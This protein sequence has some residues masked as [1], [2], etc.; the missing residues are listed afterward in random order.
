MKKASKIIITFKHLSL[1]LLLLA[2]LDI[3]VSNIFIIP[4]IT[5]GTIKE[6]CLN[7]FIYYYLKLPTSGDVVIPKTIKLHNN[8]YVIT[9]IGDELFEDNTNITS[10]DIPSTVQR[11]GAFAFNNCKGLK[12]VTLHEGLTEIGTAAFQNSGIENLQIPSSVQIIDDFAFNHCP[13]WNI[14]TLQLPHHLKQLGKNVL[15][16]THIF[17]DVGSDNEFTNFKINDENKFYT[18]DDGILYTKDKHT[19]ISIPRGKIFDDNTYIMPDSVTNLAEMAFSRNKNIHK[20]ILSDNLIVDDKLSAEEKS[21]YNVW[22]N[23]LSDACY[24]YTA[25]SEY[26]AKPTNPNYTTVDGVLYSKDL[27]RL[28]AIPNHYKGVLNIPEGVER[29]EAE[30][31]WTMIDYTYNISMNKITEIHIPSSLK[32]MDAKQQEAINKLNEKYGTVISVA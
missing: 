2:S 15:Y 14:E 7:K 26:V 5:Q 10:I 17:Y 6:V 22:T 12:N 29:W 11:I 27:K 19:L 21:S 20:I 3:F 9:A 13:N 1:Y 16:P 4:M 31:L 32:Y 8:D 25:V 30:A 28:I 24:A 18:V 23:D